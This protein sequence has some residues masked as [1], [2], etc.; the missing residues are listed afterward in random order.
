[1]FVT[2][3][4]T[5]EVPFFFVWHEWFSRKGRE[6]KIYRCGLALSSEPQV[7]KFHALFWQTTSNIAPKSVPH[8]Q[9]DYFSSF[10]QSNHWFV[11]LSWSLPSSFVKLPNDGICRRY[12]ITKTNNCPARFRSFA[13]GNRFARAS[14]PS[15]PVRAFAL[16]KPLIK[17][18]MFEWG[19]IS[20]LLVQHA[21]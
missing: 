4:E 21:F 16:L 14:H 2:L 3:Y 11:A 19:K 8:V 20:V 9:H 12:F 13:R 6:W 18:S 17:N 1:M 10:K 7:W 15:R 5:G